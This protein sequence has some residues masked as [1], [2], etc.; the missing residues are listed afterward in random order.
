MVASVPERAS[1]PPLVRPLAASFI[2][3]MDLHVPARLPRASRRLHRR[4]H[5]ERLEV[6]DEGSSIPEAAVARALAPSYSSKR[7]GTGL[8]LALARELAEVHDG[9]LALHDREGEGLS[10][11]LTLPD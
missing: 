7:S 1:H 11:A 4:G 10:V 2:R 8:G 9:R 3:T 5:H 6:L